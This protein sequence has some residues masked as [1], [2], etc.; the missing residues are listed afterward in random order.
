MAEGR[1]GNAKEVRR[2]S[3][4]NEES[5]NT[6]DMPGSLLNDSHSWNERP[7]LR[8]GKISFEVRQKT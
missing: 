8:Q 7:F 4:K 2:G 3:E 6:N 1:I 5:F